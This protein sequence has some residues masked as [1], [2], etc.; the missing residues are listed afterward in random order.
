MIVHTLSL[1]R[2]L[3]SRIG[4]SLRIRRRLALLQQRQRDRREELEARQVETQLFFDQELLA[5][6]AR[7][8]GVPPGMRIRRMLLACAAGLL[9]AGQAMPVNAEDQQTSGATSDGKGE[10]AE[11][12][13]MEAL[14]AAWIRDNFGPSEDE[15]TLNDDE[16]PAEGES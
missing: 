10:S 6:A 5:A 16:D 14:L 12:G 11:Q 9:I 1:T 15:Q 8:A 4:R 2:S 3:L 7:R 13:S